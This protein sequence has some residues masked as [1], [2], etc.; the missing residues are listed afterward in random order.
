M[1]KHKANLE[2]IRREPALHTRTSP[3]MAL[4]AKE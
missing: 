2:L 1:K 3:T 4:M